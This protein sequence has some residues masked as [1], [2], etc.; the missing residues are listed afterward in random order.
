MSLSGS[1]VALLLMA[2]KPLYRNKL[3]QSFQYYMW[4][5]VLAVLLLPVSAL[6]QVPRDSAIPMF[7]PLLYDIVTQNVRTSDELAELNSLAPVDGAIGE[8]GQ[9][10]L[11][12]QFGQFGQIDQSGQLDPS[13]QLGQSDLSGQIGITD[14]IEQ[15]D[16]SGQLQQGVQSRF[17]ILAEAMILAYP[18]GVILALLYHLFTYQVYCARLKRSSVRTSIHFPIPVYQSP[19][20]QTPMLVG[21]FR[22]R[23]VLPKRD[24]TKL[25]LEGVLRHEMIHFRRKDVLIKW[26]SVFTCAVHWFNPIVW[27]TRRE[28]SRACELS[29]DEAVIAGFDA[30]GKQMY[31]ETLILVAADDHKIRPTLAMGEDKRELKERLTNIMKKKKHTRA[32][33]A[34]L[35]GLLTI[36]AAVVMI[37]GTGS[38]ENENQEP[39]DQIQT[40]QQLLRQDQ[41]MGEAD[42]FGASSNELSSLDGTTETIS[43]EPE[44]AVEDNSSGESVL[45]SPDG[46]DLL[47]RTKN[48]TVWVEGLPEEI[49]V[50]LATSRR[51]D[52]GI[53]L[54]FEY[55]FSEMPGGDSIEQTISP[56]SYVLSSM[57]IRPMEA[58]ETVPAD[59]QEGDTTNKYWKAELPEMTLLISVK[60]S[61]LFE[62]GM[63]ARMRLFT[64]TIFD[65]SPY[66]VPEEEPVLLSKRMGEF[67]ILEARI[68]ALY[69]AYFFGDSLAIQKSLSSAFQGDIEV[70]PNPDTSLLALGSVKGLYEQFEDIVDLDRIVVS[71]E[72]KDSVLDDS[73]QYLTIELVREGDDWKVTS[74]GVEK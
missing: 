71:K 12:G 63:G 70:H 43:I 31:G 22:P 5:V 1:I 24:F 64:D 51:Y 74:Y 19:M 29:C 9:S 66:Q 32:A 7:Q 62:E 34:M 40:D 14:Q 50:Y 27:L 58:G 13:G 3:H 8:P 21:I 15:F 46:E 2:G 68:E 61:T 20:A 17:V 73:S 67:R 38:K 41:S 60:F 23:I 49:P 33:V 53:Y 30:A 37:L 44:A 25:Q 16:R 11:L 69:M 42:E 59:S 36:S 35:V 48:I 57:M 54:P 47:P 4:L 18:I 56:N 6:I 10:G 65:L 26:L 39:S 52:Y 28:I 72:F 45:V 55:E